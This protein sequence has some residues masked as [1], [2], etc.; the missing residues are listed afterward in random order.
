MGGAPQ[1]QG[2]NLVEQ[3]GILSYQSFTYTSDVQK[4][5]LWDSNH[6]AKFLPFPCHVIPDK[7]LGLVVLINF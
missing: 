5:N 2:M 3:S 1:H 7:F 6:N 4:R